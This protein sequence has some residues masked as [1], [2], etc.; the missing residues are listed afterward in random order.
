MLLA[1]CAVQEMRTRCEGRGAG[2]THTDI[3]ETLEMG[4]SLTVPRCAMACA[5]SAAGA[6]SNI[7]L[8]L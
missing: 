3:L 5:V 7:I 1:V 4:G 6:D 2:P 8:Q